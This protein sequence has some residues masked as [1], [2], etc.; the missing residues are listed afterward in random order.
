M[1]TEAAEAALIE[2]LSGHSVVKGL[3]REAVEQLARHLTLVQLAPG[4]IA[5]REGERG[6]ELFFVVAGEAVVSRG[7]LRMQTLRVGGEFG[8]LGMLTGRTRAA[9]VTATTELVLA[10]L[11]P[12]SWAALKQERPSLAL[13]V[14]EALVAQIRDDLTHVT[15][16]V[17]SLLRGRSLPRS[18]EVHVRVSGVVQVVATGTLIGALLP[19]EANGHLVV[20]GLLGHKPVALTTPLVSD[21]TLE[22]LTV[23]HWEGRQI[24]ARSVGLLLLEAANEL[25]PRLDLQLGPSLGTHQL[26]EVEVAAAT[27]PSLA[28]RL[29]EGMTA[30]ADRALP[31]RQEHWT[32]DEARQHF[33]ARGWDAPARLL[34]THRTATVPLVAYVQV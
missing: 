28:T 1:T 3:D 34:T 21:G 32:V 25:D 13:L 4:A 19:R 2:V 31:L 24:Y 33:L 15:D 17:G 27:L 5:V 14:V 16:V 29:L 30:L 18:G 6:D 8:S 11:G 7:S 9:T 12:D 20:A 23:E 10:R 26:L 22:P